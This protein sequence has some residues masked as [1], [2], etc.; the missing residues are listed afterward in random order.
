MKKI[1]TLTLCAMA[2]LAAGAQDQSSLWLRNAAVS[3][4]GSQ[5]AFTFKGNIFTVPA[6]GGKATQITTSQHYDSTPLWSP[7]GRNLVFT[8]NRLGSDDIYIIPS[9]GGTARR[10]TTH[11]GNETPL[12][13]LPDGRLLFSANIMPGQTSAQAPFA[14]QT[15][16]I[17]VDAPSARPELYKSLPMAAASANASGRILYQDRKGYENA[18]RKHE[19]SSATADVW[20]IDTDGSFRQ[21]TD[22]L[23]HDL[24]PV[25]GSGDTFFY[26]SEAGN[27]NLNIYRG[28]TAPGA[29]LEQLTSHTGMPVRSLSASADGSVLAY[30]LG[31]ELYTLTPGGEPHKLNV[32][33]V[34][35]DFNPDIIKNFRN[36]GATTLSVNS[37]GSEVAFVIR[38][39]VYA[40]SVKYPTTARITN[41]PG[42]ERNV[43]IAPDGR[44][45]VYDSERDGIWGLYI[46]KITDPS[47]KQLAY[48]TAFTEEPLY[49][50]ATSAQQPLFSPDGKNVAF[51]EDRC[52][53]R[54]IDLDTKKVTTA[55]SGEYNYSYTDGDIDFTWSP[56]SK[57]LLVNYIGQGGWNNSDIAL[58]AADGTQVVDLTESGYS[59]SQPR[60]AMGGRAI[61]YSTGKYGMKSHGSWGN[62]DDI[63]FMALD[64]EAWDEFNLTEEEAAL[65]E[66]A[67]KERKEKEESDK[68]SKKSK[69]KKSKSK[70]KEKTDSDTPAK[71]VEFDL[72]NRRYRTARLT[73]RS[74]MVGDYYLSPKADKFYYVAG[75]TEAG[76]NLYCRDLRKGDTKVLAKG[77]SGGFDVDSKGENLF[78]LSSKGMSKIALSDGTETPIEFDAPYNRHPSRERA[79]IFDH[80]VNQVKNKF[81]DASLHSLPWDSIAAAHRR[82]LP[83][84]DNNRDFAILLSELLGELNASHTGASTSAYSS[85]PLMPTAS[86]GAYFDS[87]YT[88]NGLRI[89][90]IL[91]RGP[92]DTRKAA[93]APGDVITA[94]DGEPIAAGTD[95]FPLLEGKAGKNVLLTVESPSG[96]TRNITVKPISAGARNQLLYQRW[97]EHNE[98]LVDSLSGGRLAYVHVEGMDSPSFRAV[99]DRLLGRYRNAEAAIVDTRWN[100]GG[101]LHN[102]LAILLSG[103]EYVRF[104]PR[105]RYIGSEPFSQWTK[106]SVMLV[107]ES[108]YSDAHGTPFVYQT[109]GIGDVVGAPVPGTMTAVWWETQIDPSIVFGIPQ[110]TSQAMDGTVLENHQLTPDVLIYNNPAD[111][112]AGTDAQLE[113]AVKHLLEKLKTSTTHD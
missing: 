43:D 72:P 41:T 1:T 99:Y 54:V 20:L 75:S 19:R 51:L 31:G 50:C 93:V 37:K 94:I 60:W 11:S 98:H 105:G 87:S 85:A 35:D 97:V 71:S 42:Q 44:S 61:T 55:L 56:D 101:W 79:Y 96:T 28:S 110:V 100:G 10:L 76:S 102:D 34:T 30:S 109:L 82:F 58:V 70:G 65:K 12:T 80:V 89:A 18:W 63:M 22:F 25:W 15:Y 32:E 38:G 6:T 7:D 74:A 67:E 68:D 106:P 27:N 92:L 16:V 104:T 24:N 21:L 81:Y 8:S 14:P 108:N 29:S 103:K 77:V 9:A 95:Y 47:Q 64:P 45:V 78:V 86:L 36:S 46:S 69:T 107:N 66:Q 111:V 17:N 112:D 88:G 84:I 40:T 13:F 73:P 26:L 48:A 83:Y 39:D 53:L 3:P 49:S 5:V 90:E 113:G 2:A 57:W 62:Q 52:T 91:H 33:I 4:D 59:D 23:G